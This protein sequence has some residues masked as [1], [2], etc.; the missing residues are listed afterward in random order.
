M[1]AAGRIA[2]IALTRRG[3]ARARLLR[4]RLKQGEI[5]RPERFGPPASGWE[6]LFTGPLSKQVPELFSRC[7]QLV[8][9]LAAGAVTRLIAPFLASKTSDP[10][11]LALDEAG[12]FVVPLLSGHQ[13]GANAFARTVAGCLGAIPVITTAS[14]VLAGFSPDL[15]EEEFGWSAE[16]AE[17][18]KPAAA[19]LLNNEPVALIQELGSP[20]R[21]L[22][23]RS[24]PTNITAVRDVSRLP[25]QRYAWV[26]WITDRLVSDCGELDPERILWYRPRSLVLGVGCERGVSAT[27]FEEALD[28]F[29]ADERLARASIR[30]LASIDVKADEAAVLAVAGKHGW[31]TRFFSSAELAGVDGIPNPSAVV[32]KCVGTPGV[33]EPAALRASGAARLL[34]EKQVVASNLAPQRMTFALARAAEFEAASEHSRKVIF[35]GAG[36]GDPEL[37]TVKARNILRRADVVVYAGSLIPEAVL[38]EAAGTAKLVNSAHLTLE[39]VMDCLIEAVRAGRR[40]VRLQSG[41]T[42]IYSAIQEQMTLLDAASIGYEVVPGISSFQAAAAALKAE[43]TLPEVVQTI[44]L[45]RGE[46]ETRMPAGEELAALARHGAT[47]CVFLSARLASAVEQ[48]LLTAYPPETPAAICH[49]V[50]WPDEK[51][52]M[53][54]LRNLSAAIQ[55]HQ[56][57]RTTLILVG[58]ALGERRNRSR[59]YDRTHGH[60]FRAKDI[61]LA[62][63]PEGCAG[64]HPRTPPGLRL[65]D[66]ARSPTV[67]LLS[68]THEGPPLA[69]ALVQAGFAVRATVT[70]PEACAS[71]FGE[72]RD[73]IVVE[74]CGF[75]G[76]SLAALLATGE[77]DIVVDATH[78][79]AVRITQLAH[80]ACARTGTPHIRY[81]RP[82]WE[83]PAGTQFADSFVDAAA[84]L[85]TLGRRVLLTIGAK[86]LKHFAHLHGELTLFARLLPAP[87]SVQQALDAGFAPDRIL[88]LRPPF[89]R[90]FNRAI[91]QEHGVD[92]LV[93]KA[94]GAEGGVPEKVL[95]AQDLGVRVLMIRRPDSAGIVAFDNID[96]VV[97]ECVRLREASTKT[98]H[99]LHR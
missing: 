16:P 87:L 22:D 70:R 91:L 17:R 25:R 42:S 9:F 53:T 82:D 5:V 21:W 52:V 32:E 26:L 71:L 24:L 8:F 28:R 93:T 77:I 58:A 73:G 78:P 67:L 81:E 7:D 68:G 38:S 83:P 23:E 51:I 66:L 69:Q 48:Q 47:L 80:T 37:L 90:E 40:V 55:E 4:V 62:A 29:L 74:A 14:D 20:G 85:P 96:T 6:R 99:G 30:T 18:L 19:A 61:R 54:E 11:V 84:L 12:R 10:G 36:P 2:L 33:A 50:S 72:K 59:L 92:L 3:L 75:T 57:T 41:D 64:A 44:I 94:S 56:F 39:Q 89:S 88:A 27:A 34:V 63:T 46:G 45:T 35:I 43:L 49:R 31:E 60:L 98:N 79:F 13:G 86:Q 76:E 65:N 1:S 95:A 15:I 97:R